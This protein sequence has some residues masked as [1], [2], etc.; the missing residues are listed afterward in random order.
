[1][2]DH[3]L[4]KKPALFLAP[5]AGLTHAPFRRLL[6]DFGGYSA[7]YS[8]ML[9]AA[10]LLSQDLHTSPY[11]KRR[12]AEGKVVYQLQINNDSP[13][14]KIV[15][16]LKEEIQPWAL[17]L[18]LGCPAPAVRKKRM[19]SALFEHPKEVAQVLTR[20]HSVWN[21]PLSIKSRLGSRKDAQW[22]THLETLLNLCEKAELDWYT[23]HARFWEDGR[24]RP[25]QTAQYAR[26]T[27]I[28]DIPLIAN[29]EITTLPQLSQPNFTS[30]SGVMIGR[31]AIVK[32]WIFKML[33]NPHFN[34]NEVN[35]AEVWAQL[36]NYVKEEFIHHKAVGRMKQFTSYYGQNFFYGHTLYSQM[37]NCTSLDEMYEVV[38]SFLAKE[39]R[40]VK[41]IK[42]LEL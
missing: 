24:K 20:I 37:I 23:I 13:I 9:A 39:Q 6:S 12:A 5:L 14:E 38:M 8:E 35:Y 25:I 26:I 31:M 4:F 7:L 1:M 10:P 30:L 40:M 27:E 42:I 34:E 15:T 28:T 3:P 32:P 22:F 18:N 33:S 36:F 41:S 17:D 19:G 21:G 2:Q 16:R 11:T 29:G